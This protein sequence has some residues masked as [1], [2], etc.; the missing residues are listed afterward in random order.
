MHTLVQ[1]GRF[2]P[3]ENAPQQVRYRGQVLPQ[4]A[5][6]TYRMDDWGNSKSRHTQKT[7][8]D[9]LLNA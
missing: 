6:L 5:E 4:S 8:I 3:L 2:Q 9:I 7:N 1:N